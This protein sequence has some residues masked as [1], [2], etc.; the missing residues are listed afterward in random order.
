MRDGPT[1]RIIERALSEPGGVIRWREA[2]EEYISA[3]P[4]ARTDVRRGGP[5]RFH[6]AL[7]KVLQKHFTKV[8]GIDGY[9]VHNSMLEGED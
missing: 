8:E 3:S 1:A 9:Y 4:S 7:G 6:M 2:R 5:F